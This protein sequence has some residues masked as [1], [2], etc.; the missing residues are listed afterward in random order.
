MSRNKKSHD[1]FVLEVYDMYNSEYTVLGLYTGNKNKITVRH[2]ICNTEYD[3]R[4]D[5]FLQGR[6]C[7]KCY[8][9]PKKTTDEYKK[10]VFNLCGDEYTVLGEYQGNK[11]KI[12]MKHNKCGQ[13][14]YV[15]PNIFISKGNR[16]PGC[17]QS[18]GEGL[19][20][21]LLDNYGIEY[22]REYVFDDCIYIKHLRF[23]F[24]L[25][26]FNICIEYNG[27]QHYEVVNAFGGVREFENVKKRDTIKKQYCYNKGLHLIVIPYYETDIEDILRNE[28]VILD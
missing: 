26:D 2:N 22:I 14:W 9:T 3:V 7:F 10:E 15:S 4:P 27:R 17:K 28:G 23:D 11:V 13:T 18:K 1:Q 16:C 21:R 20:S 24:Y 12:E 19:I 25:P 6:R 5:K 8:G